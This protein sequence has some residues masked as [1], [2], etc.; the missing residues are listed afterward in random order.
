MEPVV[1]IVITVVFIIT[2]AIFFF[3]IRP[4]LSLWLYAIFSGAKVRLADIAGMRLEKVKHEQ[5]RNFIRSVIMASKAGISVTPEELDDH[6]RAGGN[7]NQLVR[8]MILAEKTNIPLTFEKAASINLSAGPDVLEAVRMRLNPVI[9]DTQKISA[10][11]KQD[12]ELK[13]FCRVTLRANIDNFAGADKNTVMG[14]VRNCIEDIISNTDN[15][16]ELIEN[17]Y[18]LSDYVMSIDH[19]GD[20][21]PDVNRNAAFEVMSVDVSNVFMGE[22]PA[23]GLK[24]EQVLADAMKVK[25][26]AEKR[27]ADAVRYEEELKAGIKEMQADFI[28][29]QAEIPLALAEAIVSAPAVNVQNIAPEPQYTGFQSDPATQY[30]DPNANQAA[31]N[32]ETATNQATAQNLGNTANQ[33]AQNPGT[34]TNQAEQHPELTQEEAERENL[35]EAILD[36]LEKKYD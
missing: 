17:P 22:N 7:M 2:G 21:I 5:I 31:Q 29:A 34:N 10:R 25:A 18:Q 32:S 27:Y 8:A 23:A 20:G 30:S 36:I 11:T 4:T 26:E 9:A 28:A 6:R 19:E 15:Y 24:A 12:T 16:Q 13:V 35:Y 1:Y 33:A 14:R 3:F